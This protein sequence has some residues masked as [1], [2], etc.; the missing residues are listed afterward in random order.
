MR[1]KRRAKC[2]NKKRELRS[3]SAE[4]DCRVFGKDL[5]GRIKYTGNPQHK[6]NPGNFH[7]TPPAA[8]CLDKSLCDDAEV[9]CKQ[10]AEDLLLMGASLGLVDVRERKNYPITIWSVR[11]HDKT[12]F[13]AQLENPE[14]G[15]YHGYPLTDD[16]GF[17][18]IILKAYEER[19]S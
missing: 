12:V 9:C 4:E 15:Q 14:Q 19:L 18:N 7:L 2:G 11:E 5:A 8:P 10:E 13:E 6:R 17:K 16:D 1:Q 3:W